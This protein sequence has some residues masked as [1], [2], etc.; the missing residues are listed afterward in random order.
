LTATNSFTVVVREV[1]VAPSLPTQSNRVSAG[2]ATVTVTNTATN[3]NIHATNSGY[4]LTSAPAGA[5]ISTNGIITWTPTVSQVPST[6][7]FTTVVT[8]TDSFDLVNP[9]LTATNSFTVTVN[10]VHNGPSLPAQ[11]HPDQQ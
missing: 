8:N 4:V 9:H 5:S 11:S 10:A 2:L 6:N 1:N 7:L 3:A